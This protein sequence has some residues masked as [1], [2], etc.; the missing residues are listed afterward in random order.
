MPFTGLTARELDGTPLVD[1]W[2]R[3][4]GVRRWVEDLVAVSV[5]PLVHLLQGHGIALEAHAQNMV[6]VHSGGRPRRLAVKDF[7]D[8]I[9]FSRTQLADPG[10]CPQLAGTPAHHTNRN[11]FLETDDLDLVTDFLLD[12]FFFINLGE[13]AIFLDDAYGFAEPEFW[14][15]VRRAI[16][17]Y[18][19]RHPELADRFTRFDVFKPSLAVEKLTTR[20]LQP[21]TELRL[22]TVPN[23]LAGGPAP[24]PEG[25]S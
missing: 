6:L 5:L 3:A 13:L 10:R 20:R 16:K 15:V 11:S 8:G 7:H 24:S 14:A 21:D 1:S 18:Q 23:P 12:A 22:H 4:H 17:A 9:R 25:A 19:R 2:V